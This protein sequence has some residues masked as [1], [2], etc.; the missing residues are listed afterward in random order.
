MVRH[1]PTI[2]P[3]HAT[4]KYAR[5]K[6]Q[7]H[8]DDH[9]VRLAPALRIRVQAWKHPPAGEEMNRLFISTMEHYSAMKRNEWSRGTARRRRV[10]K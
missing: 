2:R 7:V 5:Q 10:S 9:T 3:S 6:T 8:T 4:S 1:I